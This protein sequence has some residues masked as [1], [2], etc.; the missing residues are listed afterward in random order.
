MN[1]YYFHNLKKSF[2]KLNS[3]LIISLLNTFYSLPIIVTGSPELRTAG[4]FCLI[5]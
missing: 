1:K 2:E 3:S 4:R 5:F